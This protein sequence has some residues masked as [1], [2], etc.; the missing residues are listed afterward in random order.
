[1]KIL[2]IEDEIKLANSIKKGLEQENYIVDVVYNGRVGHDLAQTEDYDVI[3]LDLMLPEIDGVEICKKLR[4]RKVN[5]AILML[6]AKIQ[7]K[8]KIL[9]L[10]SGADDY[11]T[12]PFDFEELLA[13]IRALNRRSK[14]VQEE[15]IKI[16]D[17]VLNT[18]TF[19]VKRGEMDIN[20][21]N[22][23]FVL[24]TFLLKNIG[25]IVSKEEI[26]RNVWDYNSD[27]LPNTVEVHVKKLRE[28][29][30]LAFKNKPSIIK[31]IRGFGY[32]VEK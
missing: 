10:N 3:I 14:I 12:K 17:L 8:D 9:G 23:E 11:L 1:M 16:D 15:I 22:K 20:L 21:S 28:K 5:S 31:T 29:I 2:I 4:E 27:V 7:T 32:K 13:R 25:R 30:D 19:E 26:I 24:L 6:T 18:R